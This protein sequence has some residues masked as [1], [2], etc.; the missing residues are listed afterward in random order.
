MY[1]NSELKVFKNIKFVGKFVYL[2]IGQTIYW[3]QMYTR[4]LLNHVN[5]NCSLYCI[6]LI[7]LQ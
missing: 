3:W 4:L 7:P 1:E 2:I 5:N 6:G